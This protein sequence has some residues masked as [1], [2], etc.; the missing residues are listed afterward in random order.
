MSRSK[1]SIEVVI[2]PVRLQHL[3]ALKNEMVV[4]KTSTGDVE[5]EV[6]RRD[7]KGLV[8]RDGVLNLPSRSDFSCVSPSASTLRDLNTRKNVDFDP[9]D[10]KIS[11]ALELT[12]FP[13]SWDQV[14]ISFDTGDDPRRLLRLRLWYLEWFLPRRPLDNGKLKGVLHS[15]RGP[16]RE[17][18][19]WHVCIDM[20]SAPTEALTELFHVLASRG[21]SHLTLGAE[22]DR[23]EN[24]QS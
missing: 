24:Q 22:L 11:D 19:T 21:V 7:E 14:Q 8:I 3:A 2:D 23:M 18:D 10:L 15:L 16:K 4:S 5:T 9:V 12:I 17:G 6:V 13:F 20:G 1:A